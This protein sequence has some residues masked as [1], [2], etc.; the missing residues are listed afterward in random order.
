MGYFR[1]LAKMRYEE[2]GYTDDPVTLALGVCE[3]AGELGKAINFF[4]NPLYKSSKN[5][6][7][8]S[9]EHE[10]IDLLIYLGALANSLNLTVDF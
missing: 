1:N 6:Q 5:G 2:R 4:H 10:T 7:S 8:D 9:V 3:E